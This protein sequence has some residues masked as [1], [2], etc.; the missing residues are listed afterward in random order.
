MPVPQPIAN[1]QTVGN[2]G[3][4][5]LCCRLSRMG[6]NDT[7]TARN[8]KGIDIL[9]YSQDACQKRTIQVKALSK[10]SPVPLSNNLDHLFADFAVV[11]RYVIREN[12]ECFLLTSEEVGKRVHEGKKNGK[13]SHWLQP[14]AYA[15]D[16]FCELDSAVGLLRM[17]PDP[18]TV[19]L[20]SEMRVFPWR[21][22][23]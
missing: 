13:V 5:F 23:A 22:G 11:C 20:L 15:T 12:P 4:F 7:S 14:R 18:R 8:A 3:L 1:Q 16:E 10:G 17:L 2:I 9:T 19:V 6:W 21:A